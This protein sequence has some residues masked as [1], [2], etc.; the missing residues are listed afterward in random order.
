MKAL[1]RERI[2]D[3]QRKFGVDPL[4]WKVLELSSETSHDFSHLQRADIL[5]CTPEKWDL[6]SRGWCTP[7]TGSDVVFEK[8][9]MKQIRLLVIDEVHLL[10]EER[11]AVLEAIVSRTRFISK[12]IQSQNLQQS[13]IET[14][15]NCEATR[16]VAL[17]TFLSNPLDLASWIG[18]ETDPTKAEFSRGLYNFGHSVRPVPTVIHTRGFPGK[19]YCPR[20]ATMNKPC[21]AAIRE[22]SP[23]KPVLIFVA[24]RRQ[25]RLTAFDIISYTASEENS[26]MFLGC[27]DDYV[28]SITYNIRDETLRHTIL[29]GVAV[30]H[31]GL[32]SSDRQIVEQLFLERKIQVLVAT[33]TLAWGVNLPAHLVIVKGTE[34]FDAKTSKYVDYPLTDVLQM[35]GRAGRPGFDTEAQALVMVAEDKKVFFKKFLFTAFPVES[36]LGERLCET[37]NAEIVAGTIKSV[38]DGLGYMFWTFFARRVRANPSYY[39]AKSSNDDDVTNLLLNVVEQ[40][41]VLLRK[42]GCLREPA[43]DDMPDIVSTTLGTACSAYYLSYQTPKQMLLGLHE[44][45]RILSN[46]RK[47]PKLQESIVGSRNTHIEIDLSLDNLTISWLLYIVCSTHEFDEHPVRH[48][49]EILNENLNALVKWGTHPPNLEGDRPYVGDKEIFKDPHTKCFLLVQAYV[50]RIK[51]PIIDYENDTKMVIENFPRLLAAVEFIAAEEI[52]EGCFDLLTQLCRARQILSTRS[53]V[54]SSPLSQLLGLR[55]GVVQINSTKA[56]HGGSKSNLHS[57]RG[58]KR[59]DA[60]IEIQIASKD[61]NPVH[62]FERVV[63]ALFQCPYIFD[64]EISTLELDDSRGKRMGRV[65]VSLHMETP[66]MRSQKNNLSIGELLTITVLL[67]TSQKRFLLAR[68]QLRVQLKPG[69]SKQVVKKKLEFDW[70]LAEPECNK[71]SSHLVLRAMFNEFRGLD[72]ESQIRF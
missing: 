2:K 57:L 8:D 14:S 29:F 9:F 11:G 38:T 4:N 39:G 23:S 64:I 21:F 17:S 6:I 63:D 53:S 42:S 18:I 51:L 44:I 10:G 59:E 13:S 47:E 15:Y 52:P 65:S 46:W 28:E 40:A 72:I 60:I 61:Q 27:S 20:M 66:S 62:P 33:S 56:K 1:A 36:C 3:W 25:T 5:I 54:E 48:N 37:L 19:H 58:L 24:S 22:L 55:A 69:P 49:E 31:A 43:Q 16:I 35:V 71:E 70:S 45:R 41:V 67:G 32:S 68:S 30:H 7:S 50:E 34:Y 12:L 26:K